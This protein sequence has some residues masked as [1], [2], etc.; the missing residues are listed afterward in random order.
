MHWSNIFA[1]AASLVTVL[2]FLA[3]LVAAWRWLKRWYDRTA[4]SRRLLSRHL[5]ALACGV[6]RQYIE[7]LFGQPTFQQRIDSDGNRFQRIYKTAHGW[8]L[9]WFAA[10][11]S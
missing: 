9:L 5:N 11:D 4:G 6:T 10:D 1:N 7:N 2:A 3:P 8:L